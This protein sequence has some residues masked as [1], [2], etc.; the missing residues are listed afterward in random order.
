MGKVHYVTD[1]I[2]ISSLNFEL[3][4]D[5]SACPHPM[6]LRYLLYRSL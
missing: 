3:L 5:F 2:P 1:Y 4:M 6:S